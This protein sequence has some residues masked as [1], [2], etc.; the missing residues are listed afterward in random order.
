MAIQVD[1][2]TVIDDSRNITNVVSAN[3]TSLSIG[4]T[5]V[6][7]SADEL[8][9]L[10]GTSPNSK[11]YHPSSL[12]IFD[13]TGTESSAS[14]TLSRDLVIGT[15]PSGGF[16]L[17]MAVTGNDPHTSSYNGS[18]W[19]LAPAASGQTWE[20][21]V[22]VKASASTTGQLFIFGVDSSG[23]FINTFNAAYGATAINITTEWTEVS[24]SFTFSDANVAFIQTRLDGP[25]SGGAGIN[26]WWDDLRVYRKIT[27]QDQLDGVGFTA[28]TLVQTFTAGQTA[29]LTVGNIN[30]N[31]SSPVAVLKDVSGTLTS[32]IPGT[33]YTYQYTSNTNI[34]F[35][36][37]T[38]GDYS[39]RALGA[40]DS[41][42]EPTIYL[43]TENLVLYLDAANSS[44]YSG[45][46]TTWSDLSGNDYDGTLTNGPVYNSTYFDFDGDDDYV[47][48]GTI[49]TSHPLQLSSPSGGGL[50]IMFAVWFDGTG[51]TFQRVVDKSDSGS[52][53]NGWAIWD[54]PGAVM[55]FAVNNSYQISTTSIP[56][57]NTWEI[58]TL[59]HNSSTGEIVWYKNATVDKSDTITY[60]M[61]NVQTNMRLG[62]WN[63]TDAR[64]LNGRLGFFMVYDK[65]LSAQEVSDNFEVL[66]GNYGFE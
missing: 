26:V 40:R 7:A 8:N 3:V 44:S 14:A 12:D 59:T 56:A 28:N 39:I 46:G 5:A 38:A 34:Q 2:T 42:V 1:G 41:L 63:H 13:W 4:G 57:S 10:V 30:T 54:T 33:D 49:G 45:S 19:N 55:T 37:L 17:K 50:T 21:K 43:V 29:N 15:S 20:I 24:Y 47:D 18:E 22:Y 66:K 9:L 60:N 31:F 52:A 23:N 25:D 6:T 62:T 61:P 48:M 53:A 64:E 27:L 51:D 58:W 65:P 16:P 35:K 32:A 11:N 36:A